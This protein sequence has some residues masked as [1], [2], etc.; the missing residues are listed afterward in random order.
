MRRVAFG[1]VTAGVAVLAIVAVG[2]W[3]F[4]A[5]MQHTRFASSAPVSSL[6][7]GTITVDDAAEL[8]TISS[9]DLGP[10]LYT[11]TVDYV[12]SAPDFSDA[13][14]QLH[15]NR[16]SNIVNF[17]GRP[18]DV[19]DLKVNSS[20][21]WSVVINGAGS[22]INLDFGNGGLRSL[23]TN[24]AASNVALSAGPP[25]GVVSVTMSGV[26]NRLRMHVPPSTQYRATADGIGASVGDNVET[27]GWSAA[28]DRYDVIVN[29]VGVNATITNQDALR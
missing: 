17:W 22:T 5:S 19:I 3:A 9:A 8:I 16:A 2:S 18:R 24:G 10:A 4:F 27:D 7:S 15:V 26:G 11:L 14:A 25:H 6:T 21:M 1:A 23:T 29:G 12:Y 20:V 13:G 28:P